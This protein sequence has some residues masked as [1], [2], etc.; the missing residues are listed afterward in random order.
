MVAAA[1]V[2]N[3]VG[4]LGGLK[5]TQGFEQLLLEQASLESQDLKSHEQVTTQPEL[6][7]PEPKSDTN[8]NQS[9]V[10]KEIAAEQAKQP[11]P[12]QEPEQEQQQAA[13]QAT[14]EEPEQQVET[15]ESQPVPVVDDKLMLGMSSTS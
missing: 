3:D 5:K 4:T 7:E 6:C 14:I 9:L 13:S 12:E 2:A 1:N 11:E 15:V 10:D 8:N